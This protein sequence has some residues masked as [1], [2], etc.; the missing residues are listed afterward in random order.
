[1]YTF[2][3][4]ESEVISDVSVKKNPKQSQP[5]SL[6]LH[7][8]N[9]QSIQMGKVKRLPAGTQQSNNTPVISAYN[10]IHVEHDPATNRAQNSWSEKR[11]N[12]KRRL[13]FSLLIFTRTK[14]KGLQSQLF[15][16]L[17]VRFFWHVS[18]YMLL[19]AVYYTLYS[20]NMQDIF[21]RV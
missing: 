12:S 18:L 20:Q 6:L 13:T 17:L 4:D 9:V 16:L 21:S 8:R 2:S 19:P 3:H 5:W 15:F 11:A 7:D 1:M 14:N 10:I